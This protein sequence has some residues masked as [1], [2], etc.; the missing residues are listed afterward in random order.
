MG[1]LGRPHVAIP[2]CFHLADD[3]FPR[4]RAVAAKRLVAQGWSQSKTADALGV[5]QAMV[6]KYAARDDDEQDPLVMR[7]VHELIHDL[8]APA[9]GPSA[10]CHTLSQ[11]DR[12]GL[13]DAVADMLAAE[14]RLLAASPLHVVPEV[15]LNVARAL[16]GAASAAEVLAYPA[17]IVAAGDRLVRPM[18]PE[19]GASNHLSACLFALRSQ[20]DSV[21]AI[22]NIRGGDAI[23]RIARPDAT[24]HGDGD[25][26]ALFAHAIAG[27]AARIVH[28]PGAVGVEPCLYIAGATASDVVDQILAI[29]N[30]VN[31]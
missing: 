8:G 11:R 30:K 27:R 16:D 24:L 17:R 15:G 6:S 25:R 12:P 28:D 21:H 10:W 13:D 19:L 2:A 20:D 7:L 1:L 14:Q 29:N 22:A 18:P 9:T 3:V 26:V 4:V 5:S 31:Q 23:A